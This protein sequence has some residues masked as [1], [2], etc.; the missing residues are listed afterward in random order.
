[1]RCEELKQGRVAEVFFEIGAVGQIFRV[2]F[3]HRQIVPLKM[4]RKFEE[5]DVLFAYVV[6]H[7]DCTMLLVGKPD[8][9]ASRSAKLPLQRLYLLRLRV[10]ML[11]EEFF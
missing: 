7:T 11:L 5:S 8:N 10:E 1:M 2:D 9:P 3:R 6:Q 4:A